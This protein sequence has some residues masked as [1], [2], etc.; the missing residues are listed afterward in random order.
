MAVTPSTARMA[1]STSARLG[2][3]TI[4]ATTIAKATTTTSSAS[5]FAQTNPRSS[6]AFSCH[7]TAPEIYPFL[8]NQPGRAG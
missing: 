4:S 5:R 6:L 8:M 1:V 3:A 7:P 2:S